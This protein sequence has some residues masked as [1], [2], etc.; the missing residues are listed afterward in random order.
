MINIGS[1][2]VL[3]V[4][5]EQVCFK[6]GLLSNT[7]MLI[8]IQ[9]KIITVR[10]WFIGLVLLE[11]EKSFWIFINVS[12]LWTRFVNNSFQKISP[13]ISLDL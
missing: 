7:K 1:V 5:K 9:N 11:R 12:V 3:S 6:Y 8:V 13:E 4:A 10:I 2:L